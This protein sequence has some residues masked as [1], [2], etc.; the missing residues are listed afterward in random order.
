ML[1]GEA[2]NTN[3]IVDGLTKTGLEPTIYSTWGKQAN[4][5][6]TVTF[7]ILY[8]KQS[9][10]WSSVNIDIIYLFHYQSESAVYGVCEFL[11]IILN[12][13]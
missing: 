7:I 2:T 5:Y 3:S 8:K 6:T 11:K 12:Y 13:Y 1:S 9:N 10:L 4:H